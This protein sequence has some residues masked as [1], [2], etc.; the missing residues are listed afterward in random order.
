MVRGFGCALFYFWGEIMEIYRVSFI[1]HREVEKLALVEDRLETIIRDLIK[2]KEY[3]EFYMGRNGEFDVSAAS[4]VKRVQN[5]LG[6]E[7][8]SLALVLAY[9]V[10]DEEFYE[11][12]YDD[13]CMPIDSGV[14]YKAAITKRNQWMIDNSDLLIAYVN[15]DFGGAYNTLKYAEKNGVQIINVA[16]ES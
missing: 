15:K 10:K 4:V 3:V 11:N 13:I 12:Y 1:G 16:K 6:K 7:N 5:N 9:H 2:T 14:H 8:S